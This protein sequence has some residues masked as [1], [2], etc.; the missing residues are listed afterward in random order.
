MFRTCWGESRV[1]LKW[2]LTKFEFSVYKVLGECLIS[3]YCWGNTLQHTA[4][5][6]NNTLQHTAKY[7]VSVELVFTVEVGLSKFE[8]SVEYI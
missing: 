5:L 7:W 8:V 4:T 1:S 3:V 6:C 2:V